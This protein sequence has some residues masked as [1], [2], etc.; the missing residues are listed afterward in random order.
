MGFSKFV[1][2][3]LLATT[4]FA[5]AESHGDCSFK[6]SSYDGSQKKFNIILKDKMAAESHFKWLESCCDKSV[7]HIANVDCTDN[8][9]ENSVRDFSV[10]DAIYGYTAYFD[11][12][13][14]E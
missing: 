4:L 9:E 2:I 13:F 5:F 1:A 12:K 14:V 11:P 8:F 7:N 6:Y 10:E 3:S